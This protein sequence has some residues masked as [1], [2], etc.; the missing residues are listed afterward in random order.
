MRSALITGCSSGFGRATALYLLRRGW[1][2]IGTVRRESDADA[3]RTEAGSEAPHLCVV[4][5]DITKAEDV[6][7]LARVVATEAPQLHGLINNAGTAFPA[8]LELLP[9]DEFRAQLEINLVAQL[10]VTQAALPYLKAARGTIVNVSSVGGRIA[11]PLLGAYNAS[12]FA[13]EALS[14]VLRL[15]LIPFG[16]RVAVIEPG[17]SPT[18]IWKTSA[19]RQSGA[20]GRADAAP[21]AKLIERMQTFAMNARTIGFPPELFAKTVER[22]LESKNPKTRYALPGD[23][24]MRLFLRKI[25]SDRMMDRLIRRRL[26]W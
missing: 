9:I 23:I 20:E 6:A 7:A 16:I 4:I 26:D 18:E 19:A 25:L 13:L 12:K 1:R 2:V 21:Y 3:L 8:P 10:A 11:A 15:E 5:A 22:I 17:A 14:D 24:R